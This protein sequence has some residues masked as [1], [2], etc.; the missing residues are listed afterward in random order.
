ME[1]H[2]TSTLYVEAFIA[3]D[4]RPAIDKDKSDR[5][6]RVADAVYEIAN[7]MVETML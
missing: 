1:P 4:S 2:S 7:G 6:S 5:Y 3:E